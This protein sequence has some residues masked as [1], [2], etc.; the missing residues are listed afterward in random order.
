MPEWVYVVGASKNVDRVELLSRIMALL[1]RL[2]LSNCLTCYCGFK[3]F[4]IS[5]ASID[6]ISCRIVL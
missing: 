5:V 6:D 2:V 3:P 1:M 4:F